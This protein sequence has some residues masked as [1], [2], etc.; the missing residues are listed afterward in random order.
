MSCFAV[1]LSPACGSDDDSQKNPG[2]PPI[3]GGAGEGGAGEAPSG[4]TGGTGGSA[5]GT[6]SESGAATGGTAGTS[7]EGGNANEA[8]SRNEGGG[9]GETAQAGAG[10]QGGALG[11][12]GAG[13]ASEEVTCE[14]APTCTNSL[15]AVGVGDFSIAFTLTTTSAVRTGV[16]SQRAICMR[17]K[18][19]DIR[20][21]KTNESSVFSIELDDGA[22]YT[23]FTASAPLL[24]DGAPHD[25]RVCRKAGQV[26]AFADG[27]LIGKPTALS[28]TNL[29]GL[30]ALTTLTT[31]CNPYD[32]TVKL[33]GAVENICVGAL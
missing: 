2:K 11:E 7:S 13:G 9:A 33:V 22:N 31:T 27:Q 10:G 17:S 15:S 30:A 20:L 6:S 25:V 24:N 12:G 21:G 14:V 26:Y 4:G 32:G 19:W 3:D 1:V 16:I 28:K 8:G 5:A 23:S 29:N 18:F